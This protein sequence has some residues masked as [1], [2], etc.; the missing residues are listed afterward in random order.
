MIPKTKV[1]IEVARLSNALPPISEKQAEWAYNHCIVHIGRVSKKGISCL[2]CGHTW[3]GKPI[4]L[5]KL[6][7]TKCPNCGRKL[8]IK[9]T[10]KRVFKDSAYFGITTTH[11]EYQ[12]FRLFFV[13]AKFT[14]NKPPEYSC[15]EVVQHWVSRSGKKVTLSVPRGGNLCYLD[16][17]RWWE[18]LEVRKYCHETYNILPYK[19][20]PAVKYLSEIRRNGFKGEYHDLHPAEFFSLILGNNVAET[21]LKIGNIEWFKYLAH[22]QKQ[23]TKCWPAIK[24]A[25]R[26]KY[27]IKDRSLWL[28]YIDLLIYFRKDIRNP[29]V[30]FPADLHQEHNKLVAKKREIQRKMDLEKKKKQAF[31]EEEAY[32]KSKG[33]YFG[34]VFS[35]D[36]INVRVLSSV[37]DF[38][39][40]GDYMKHCVY[41]NNY[42]RKSDSLILSATINGKR[43]ETIEIS[44]KSFSVTQSRGVSNH[45]TEY[46]DR[47][48]QLVEKNMNFIRKKSTSKNSTYERSKQKPVLNVH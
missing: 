21:L 18:G 16:I 39:E 15:H 26:H 37:K 9:D 25:F 31:L 47:I 34:I 22:N 40:E 35:D 46:H 27:L 24:I 41:T 32:L 33:K 19:V 29:K 42:H 2:D 28:D 23:I 4:L 10:N 6:A 14:S 5:A 12:L 3:D 38:V 43:I 8:I 17:W 36:L 45:N 20:Y 13:S 7:G 11:Q 1:Q 30:I 48:I 44:L